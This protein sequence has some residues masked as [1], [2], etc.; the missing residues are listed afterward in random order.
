MEY[1]AFAYILNRNIIAI[2]I[3]YSHYMLPVSKEIYNSVRQCMAYPE[4]ILVMMDGRRIFAGET[5]AYSL[6]FPHMYSFVHE[7]NH[8]LIHPI[9]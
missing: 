4:P 3:N 2:S 6:I 7:Y 8:T 1:S 9:V 5:L